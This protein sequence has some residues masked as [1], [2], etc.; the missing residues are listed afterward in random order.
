MSQYNVNAE[1][2]IRATADLGEGLIVKI[3]SGEAVIATAATDISIGVTTTAVKA[4]QVAS[5]RLRNAQG[6][7]KVRAGGTIAAGAT[8]TAGADGRAVSTTTA[9]A[10]IVGIALEAGAANDFIEVAAAQYQLVAGA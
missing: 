8:L 6:T 10:Q 9:G 2:G 1:K 4:G 3:A 5:V 7:T